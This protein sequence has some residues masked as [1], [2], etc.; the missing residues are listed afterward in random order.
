[1]HRNIMKKLLFIIAPLF[2]LVGC[3]GPSTEEKKNLDN[4]TI[5]DLYGKWKVTYDDGMGDETRY[6]IYEF[7][8]VFG[9]SIKENNYGKIADSKDIEECQYDPERKVIILVIDGGYLQDDYVIELQITEI[10]E[11]GNK[12]KWICANEN[13]ETAYPVV[14]L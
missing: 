4:I 5:D 8:S 6:A 7:H 1:M 9:G 10:S 12:M 11:D 3:F 13:K 14:R 2:L